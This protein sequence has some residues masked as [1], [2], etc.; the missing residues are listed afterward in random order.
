MT[1]TQIAPHQVH[2]QLEK[3]I[4]RLMDLALARQ[5][6][7]LL[8]HVTEVRDA[9]QAMKKVLFALQRQPL[10]QQLE[11]SIRLVGHLL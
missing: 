1:V 6:E 4:D 10:E 2:G 9:A 3:R 8:F 7:A 11:A 5:D